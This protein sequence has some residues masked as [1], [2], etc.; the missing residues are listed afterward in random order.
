MRKMF[1]FLFWVALVLGVMIGLLRLTTLRWWRVP[2]NDK[3]LTASISPSVRAGDLI[4]LWRLT[5]PGFGDLVLCPEPGHPERIVIGRI[6]GEQGDRVEVLGS[7]VTV[8]GKTLRT[9]SRCVAPS[10]K[11]KAPQTGIEVEQPCSTEEAG[12]GVHLRGEIPPTESVD[13]QGVK[14]ESVPP[15]SVWLVS[16]NRYFPYDSRDYGPVERATCKE[17][18]FFR[19]VGS[20][21]FFD[22]TTRNQYIR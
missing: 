2:H 18:V 9:E 1:R 6:V 5:K 11:E 7:D 4:L 3:Y 13:P 22:T 17:T 16:D 8:D 15:G 12:S 10:F 20:G 19:L 14:I 21:G